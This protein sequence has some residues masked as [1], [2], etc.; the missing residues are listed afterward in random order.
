ME[1]TDKEFNIHA[2]TYVAG[3]FDLLGQQERLRNIRGIPTDN[4]EKGLAALRDQI[5]QSYGSV[6]G[7][8]KMFSRS[9]E[10]FSTSSPDLSNLSDQQRAEFLE[11]TAHDIRFQS[12][13]DSVVVYT[14]AL[15][16]NQRIS[17]KGILGLVGA[18]A[19][20]MLGCLAA[21]I[22]MRG[23]ID[24]GI[25]LC[26]NSENQE[27]YGP[28]LARAYELESKIAEYPRIVVGDGLFNFLHGYASSNAD[29]GEQKIAAVVA[30]ACLEFIAEDVDGRNFVDFLGQGARR[31]FGETIDSTLVANA[32][33]NVF[34]SQEQAKICRNASLAFRYAL[35]SD[36]CQARAEVWGVTVD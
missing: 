24:I 5:R 30:T 15:G 22:P 36:Y 7:F 3:F 6:V 16:P 14:P 34:E 28:V 31:H 35:L 26:I 25:G 13:S 4:D 17:L 8:R 32:I 20:S 33:R 19:G 21:G 12:L 18:A 29:D 27:F 2:G 9:F 11:C 1:D 10:G 23:G